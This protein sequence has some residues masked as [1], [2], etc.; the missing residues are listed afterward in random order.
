MLPRFT[1]RIALLANCCVR[2]CRSVRHRARTSRSGSPGRVISEESSRTERRI[3]SAVSS[4]RAA[5]GTTPARE[6]TSTPVT[7]RDDLPKSIEAGW[8]TAR[9]EPPLGWH[10]ASE[11]ANGRPARAA[12]RAE[13]SADEEGD[14]QVE[15]AARDVRGLLIRGF[16]VQVPGGAPVSDF[17]PRRVDFAGLANPAPRNRAIRRYRPQRWPPAGA[18]PVSLRLR[19][20][21][22]ENVTESA[23]EYLASA[24]RAWFIW[25]L[26]G[27]ERSASADSPGMSCAA[28]LASIGLRQLPT[29]HQLG[30]TGHSPRLGHD[31]QGAFV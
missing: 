8:I 28:P 19:F 17:A 4:D 6:L 27:T 16:G 2:S 20:T 31:A 29:A 14:A 15:G 10:R 13:P 5:S 7:Q 3:G 9:F 12:R 24:G 26:F 30:D 21:P 18:N 1:L 23:H 22:C 25:A 11:Y